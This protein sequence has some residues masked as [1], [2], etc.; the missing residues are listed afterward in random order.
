MGMGKSPN[1]IDFLCPF[2]IMP[3]PESIDIQSIGNHMALEIM[4]PISKVVSQLRWNFLSKM[5]KYL[6]HFHGHKITEIFNPTK[7]K[8]NIYLPLEV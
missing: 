2:G 3:F 4:N 6:S 7:S 5:G 1:S 8:A